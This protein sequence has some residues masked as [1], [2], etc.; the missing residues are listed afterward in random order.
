MRETSQM[1]TTAAQQNKNEVDKRGKCS[2]KSLTERFPAG[3]SLKP[4]SDG[5]LCSQGAT[6]YRY[7]T[8]LGINASQQKVLKMI[9]STL[10]IVTPPSANRYQ[11]EQT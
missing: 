8:P 9:E 2:G 7:V 10:I 6:D 1:N 5:M 11:E 3:I 4:C